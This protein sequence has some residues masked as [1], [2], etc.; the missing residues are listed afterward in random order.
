MGGRNRAEYANCQN[1]KKKYPDNPVNPVQNKVRPLKN[2][3]DS[4]F[5][6]FCQFFRKGAVK[7]TTN[8]TQIWIIAYDQAAY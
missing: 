1:K 8:Q 7:L 2:P 4:R 5:Y 6:D 3:I